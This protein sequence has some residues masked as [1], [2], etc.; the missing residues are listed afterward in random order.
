MNRHVLTLLAIVCCLSTGCQSSPL[1][2]LFARQDRTTYRTPAL[3][4]GEAQAIAA[5]A[6]GV[7]SP[8]Q[9]EL[10][11]DLARRIQAEQDPLVRESLVDAV[12]AFPMPLADQVLMAGLSDT[13]SGVR[14][15]ACQALGARGSA[16]AVAALG[17]V[18]SQDDDFDV[19]VAATKA[20][21]GIQTPESVQ[22]LVASLEDSNPA[23][24]YAAVDAM[25]SAS[26]QDLGG[27]VRA[28]LAYAK[29]ETPVVA[30]K[31]ES[32]GSSFFRRLSPF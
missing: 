14:T 20:L 8:Q 4:A 32:A 5:Q 13:D 6:T 10:L 12:A 24:Q 28:Y 3:R 22:A 7:D 16:S 15:H 25:R 31:P 17:R 18:A 26:G 29:G 23:L 19:R 30:T 21:G 9:Q 2:S 1:G 27:D 11:N